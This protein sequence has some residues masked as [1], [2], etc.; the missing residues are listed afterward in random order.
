MPI[1]EQFS[2]RP[3]ILVVGGGYVGL[4]VAMK[5]QKKVKDHGG[6]VTVVD[7]L[8]YMTY[9][10]F[11]PEV[12]GGQIEPRHVVVSH[13]QHLKHTELINGRVSAIDHKNNKAVIVPV[14]GE[15]FELEY[16]D[17][18]MAAGAVTRTFPIPGLAETG[19]GLK[20][21]EEAIALRNS[22]LER[23][24]SASLMTDAAERK[25]ALTFV[26]VGGGFAGIE[27]IAEIEDMARFAANLNNRIGKDEL[28]FVL[29]EAMGRIMPEVTEDQA[30]WVVDHL[31][32]RGIEV[33][34]NTSLADATEGKLA[35]INMP[36]KSAAETFESDTLIWTAGVM[37]N[38]MV[39]STDFP[40]E[41]RG[42]VMTGTDLRITGEDGV[43][44]EGA[45]AAGD[46]SAVPD[47]TGGLPD[48]TCVP[49]AQH[50]VRQAKLLAHNLYAT[51]YGVGHVKNYKHKN[52]GAV[53]G[54]GANKGV[55]K[56]MGIKLKGWPAWMAHRG[57]HGMAMPTFERKLRV[58]GD[59]MAALFFQRDILEL[60]NLENPRGVFVEA[61]TPKP[62]A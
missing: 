1:T 39:R 11:L 15:P 23:I 33:L 37:A 17:V 2:D 42:R 16:R 18:V 21:I 53:A 13:R 27:T 14:V 57:Y 61:A 50:A 38:P 52:M 29:V 32:S 30:L 55:A 25:R 60:N 51:R 48:G 44:I 47:V 45:W 9:Q 4:Y 36:D 20:S 10:P 28:R 59:W 49:N 12:A 46:V 24:E 35:L 54:F 31:R 41:A 56:V 6:I 3:R 34:L 62:R 58:L 8:P 43:A 7:P 26:V 5:L 19:I 22:I 40:I